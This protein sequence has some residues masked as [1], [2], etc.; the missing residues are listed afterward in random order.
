M[1]DELQISSSLN[2]SIVP[3]VLLVHSDGLLQLQLP[4]SEKLVVVG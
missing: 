2:G 3:T 4:I 1:D